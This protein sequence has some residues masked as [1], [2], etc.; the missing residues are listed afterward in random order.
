MG[1]SHPVWICSPDPIQAVMAATKAQLLVGRYPLTWHKCAGKKQLPLCPLCNVS[2]ETTTHFL[3]DCPLLQ[4]YM[5]PYFQKLHQ[6]LQHVYNRL[7]N[8]EEVTTYILDPSHA[9]PDED[10]ALILEGVTRRLWYTLQN[11][12]SIQL[13]TGSAMSRALQWVRVPGYHH[14][15]KQVQ[16]VLKM[17]GNHPVDGALLWERRNTQRSKT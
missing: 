16:S 13:G 7:H 2:P 5:E 12:W 8:K 15:R 10:T 14:N 9:S 3:L 6:L 1:F 11:Y 17:S 4:E